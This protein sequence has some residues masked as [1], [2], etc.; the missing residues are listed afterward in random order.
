MYRNTRTLGP[1]KWAT[2]L[3]FTCASTTVG[4]PTL[5][6]FSSASSSMSWKSTVSPT[7]CGNRSTSTV[8]PSRA[9]YCL[10]PDSRTAYFIALL[11]LRFAARPTVEDVGRRGSWGFVRPPPPPRRGGARPAAGRSKGGS[12]GGAGEEIVPQWARRALETL[13]R[14]PL[15]RH[16][17]GAA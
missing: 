13:S 6:P 5:T 11:Q 12:A 3:P 17:E 16:L 15:A 2:T 7:G 9:K 4:E 8:A 1:L 10:P 14:K